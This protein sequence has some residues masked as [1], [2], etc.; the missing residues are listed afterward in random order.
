MLASAKRLIG[1]DVFGSD[2]RIGMLCDLFFAERSGNV[3]YAVVKTGPWLGERE[4]L[5]APQSL[6][7]PHADIPDLYTRLTRHLVEHSPSVDADLPI[8]RVYEDHLHRHYGW[9]RYWGASPA[10]LSSSATI[11]LDEEGV[12]PDLR[13][14]R[15]VF[16][17][18]LHALDGELGHLDDLLIDTVAW[19]V[20]F[21]VAKTRNWLP[22]RTVLL[23]RE[24][25]MQVRWDAKEVTLALTRDEIKKAPAFEDLPQTQSPM[26]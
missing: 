11:V 25:V 23:P 10:D 8:N 26:A 13:G 24:S 7:E 3:R 16:G 4:I 1:R 14:M 21:F 6:D 15:A 12:D 22:G 17:H 18:H 20:A 2:D 5:L 19:E 9:S